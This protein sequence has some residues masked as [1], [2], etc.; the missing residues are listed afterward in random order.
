MGSHFSKYFLLGSIRTHALEFSNGG[1]CPDAT[2]DRVVS[3]PQG[4]PQLGISLGISIGKNHGASS[5]SGRPEQVFAPSISLAVEQVFG[6]YSIRLNDRI[7]LRK[8]SGFRYQTVTK[9]F[10]PST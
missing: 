3:C 1:S 2:P 8:V 9:I 10:P 7:K 5:K 6:D 4:C